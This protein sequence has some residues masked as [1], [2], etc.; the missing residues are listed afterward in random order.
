[1][2]YSFYIRT[3]AR[4]R[5]A[6]V[7]ARLGFPDVVAPDAHGPW[8][9]GTL[10]IY[11]AGISTRATEITY[12]DHAFQVRILA[13]A[14]SE[15]Y[16]LALRVVDQL[17]ALT[18]SQV[19]SEEG[20][21]FPAQRLQDIYDATWVRHMTESEPRVL[22]HWAKGEGETVTIAGPVRQFH[23]G[24]R[25]YSELDTA[26]PE[27]EFPQRILE[28]I[29]R[30]QYQD[31][32]GFIEAAVMEVSSPDGKK[33][34]TLS[35][36]SPENATHFV[37]RVEYL[38]LMPNNRPDGLFVIPYQALPEIAKGQFAWLDENQCLVEPVSSDN[39]PELLR[40]AERFITSPFESR[41]KWWKPWR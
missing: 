23:I 39:W 37:E 25:L 6:D 28:A 21:V 19:E 26:G 10:H 14:S 41:R 9:D 15:D 34:I 8:P 2:S 4:P 11:R 7:V 35:V 20:E 33:T 22:G 1:M 38:H 24:P 29:R 27:N 30:V 5:V 12:E 16:E 17:S 13:L 36:W 18:G 31:L 40:A 32:S 3:D